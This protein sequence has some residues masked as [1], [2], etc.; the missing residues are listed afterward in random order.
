MIPWR[1]CNSV[2]RITR[3]NCHKTML[4]C[5]NCDREPCFKA[6]RVFWE[7]SRYF[8][9]SSSSD[10]RKNLNRLLYSDSIVTMTVVKNLY[11][12]KDYTCPDLKQIQ[13]TVGRASISREYKKEPLFYKTMNQGRIKITRALW[14]SIKTVKLHLSRNSRRQTHMKSLKWIHCEQYSDKNIANHWISRIYTYTHH[15]WKVN[16]II[17]HQLDCRQQTIVILNISTNKHFKKKY[18]FSS[19][20]FIVSFI[21]GPLSPSA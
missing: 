2:A 5:Q 20:K 7:F 4:I 1:L 16:S 15:D 21:S 12:T 8:F 19:N 11:F 3:P 18:I 14:R 6:S 13:L 9:L 17:W 10:W